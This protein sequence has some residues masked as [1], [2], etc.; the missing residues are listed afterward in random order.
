MADDATAADLDELVARWVQSIRYSLA[1]ADPEV[2]V[3]LVRAHVMN[4]TSDAILSAM[5]LAHEALSHE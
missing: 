5:V 2:T 3:G 1:S 4:T